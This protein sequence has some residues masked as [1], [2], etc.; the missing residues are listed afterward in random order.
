VIS[1]CWPSVLSEQHGHQEG[2]GVEARG[3]PLEE[4]ADLYRVSLAA[5]AGVGALA[6]NSKHLWGDPVRVG[7]QHG[8]GLPRARAQSLTWWVRSLST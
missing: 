2:L 3:R 8:S 7:L 1:G 5:L 4:G 6:S